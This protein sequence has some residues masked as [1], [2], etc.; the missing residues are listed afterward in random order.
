M[1]R[2]ANI[3]GR[4]TFSSL[5]IRNFR[6]YFIGQG[7]SVSGTFMQGVALAWLVLDMT[8][9]GTVLGIVSAFQFLPILL[10]APFGGA[11]ADRVSKR[12]L[13]LFTQT[14]YGILATT[15]GVL[16]MTGSV[17]LW[18]V[19]IIA[20]AFGLF[21]AV[22]SPTRHTFVSELAGEKHLKNA[23]TLNSGIMNIARIIGPTIAGILIAGA[24]V[25]SCFVLNGLSYIAVI[26]TLFLM[27]K[28]E[29]FVAEKSGSGRIRYL[30]GF[31]Y[32]LSKPDLRIILFMAAIIG[33]LAYE[34]QVSL[35]LLA[36]VTFHGD[37]RSYAALTSAFGLGAVIGGLLF[38]GRQ[39]MDRF[40]L[41]QMA[42]LFG[43]SLFAASVMPSLASA[44]IAMVVTGVFS[45]GFTSVGNT[46]M[47]LGS[48]PK[49]RG[50]VMAFWSMAFMGSTAIGGPIVGWIGEHVGPRYGLGLGGFAALLAA[51]IGFLTLRV[52]VPKFVAR[53]SV[54][55]ARSDSDDT[56]G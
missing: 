5:G 7:I 22:D 56:S 4:D 48:A 44:T 20:L 55:P 2:A 35:P 40:V 45:I 17:R 14:A 38:A 11:V 42:L 33:T 15:L 18:M 10:F 39:R 12:N 16:V 28:E 52:S 8:G 54:I 23:V 19:Y 36:K 30:D 9:S 27:R 34:F 25:A 50:R 46:M 47:Q 24:G 41:V 6:L 13:L 29:L 49:R 53:L 21:N 51:G 32:I 1:I 31:R 37:A 26:V 43:L 3:V